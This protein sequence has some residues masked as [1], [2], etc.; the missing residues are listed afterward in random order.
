MEPVATHLP[1][2]IGV[3]TFSIRWNAEWYTSC[4][5]IRKYWISDFVVRIQCNINPYQTHWK[6]EPAHWKGPTRKVGSFSP[7]RIISFPCN[8]VS[9]SR[10]PI[11]GSSNLEWDNEENKICSHVEQNLMWLFT[12]DVK[13]HDVSLY[14]C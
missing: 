3:P 8:L 4:S 1:I 9:V 5:N 10:V 14:D 13:S 7:Q 12:K 2:L 6:N 11:S